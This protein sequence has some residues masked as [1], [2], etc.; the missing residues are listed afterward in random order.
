MDEAEGELETVGRLENEVGLETEA[1]TEADTLAGFPV[2]L[3]ART[4]LFA[5][6]PGILVIPILEKPELP[7]VLLEL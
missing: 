2:M 1:G 3:V 7:R 4:L 6:I 5:V